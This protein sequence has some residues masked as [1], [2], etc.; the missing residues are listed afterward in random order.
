MI[1]HQTNC[2]FTQKICNNPLQLSRGKV[3]CAFEQDA[4]LGKRL[5]KYHLK[6][7]RSLFFLYEFICLLNLYV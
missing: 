3:N 7:K 1:M 6:F 2:F 5:K 4:V